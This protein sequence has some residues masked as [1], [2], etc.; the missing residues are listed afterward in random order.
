[1]KFRK[2][3]CWLFGHSMQKLS[4]RDTGLSLLS[5]WKCKRCC[6]YFEEQWDYRG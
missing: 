2:M 3:L 4:E 6:E 1:M 5:Y